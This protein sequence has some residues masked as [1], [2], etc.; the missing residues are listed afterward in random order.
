MNFYL[1]NT[2]NCIFIDRKIN[3]APIFVIADNSRLFASLYEKTQL[4]D[5]RKCFQSYKLI[6]KQIQKNKENKIKGQRFAL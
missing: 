4:K 2:W 3:F 1:E 5:H 6:N